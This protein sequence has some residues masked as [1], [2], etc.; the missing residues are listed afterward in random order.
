MSS[1]FASSGEQLSLTKIWK[2]Y[3]ETEQAIDIYQ[4]EV[5]HALVSGKCVS[6]TF[7]G[8]TRKD[9]NP[10]FFQHK[11]ELEQLVSLNLMA[12]AEA[13]LRLDYLR[14][15]LRG[16]KKKNKID[17]IFKDLY[18]QKG[19]RANLRD[20]ILEMWKTVHPE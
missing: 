11:K 9:I 3:E 12:S 6:K 2:W 20:D 13:S 8:M 16:R 17:K 19:N 18:N 1:S 4:Q 10:Y 15:V 14:R 7:S 5:T